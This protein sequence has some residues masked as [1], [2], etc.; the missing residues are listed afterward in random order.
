MRNVVL[1]FGW[2][3]VLLT[4]CAS[5]EPPAIDDPASAQAPPNTTS[6]GPDTQ[7]AAA[8]S[9]RVGA[10]LRAAVAFALPASAPAPQ[11][12]RTP[13]GP[14]KLLDATSSI[15]CFA[16]FYDETFTF[17]ALSTCSVTVDGVAYSC[18][19]GPDGSC[20]IALPPTDTALA[21]IG[22]GAFDPNDPALPAG[23]TCEPDFGLVYRG[24]ALQ[25][26]TYSVCNANAAQLP[27]A[28]RTSLVCQGTLTTFA[29]TAAGSLFE[30]G[31]LDPCQLR[32]NSA[33]TSC[34]VNGANSCALAMPG[35]SVVEF[36]DPANDPFGN[37]TQAAC[38]SR[39]WTYWL[40]PGGGLVET[41]FTET[42][43][44][45]ALMALAS[46]ADTSRHTTALAGS[47]PEIAWSADPSLGSCQ[48]T[49][50]DVQAGPA[51]TP[52]AFLTASG[53]TG[54]QPSDQPLAAAGDEKLV[55]LT[56]T[57]AAGAIAQKGIGILAQ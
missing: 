53:S 29:M 52:G 19:T 34:A 5:S 26:S 9:K 54:D 27:S 46:N 1:R 50:F 51:Y 47:S 15:T 45:D 49:S 20:T 36:T 40:I 32:L 17:T 28:N 35:P 13:L 57:N 39:T 37:P 41:D 4:A 25:F 8:K 10:G 22:L 38:R 55:V 33:V 7:Q 14:S 30:N 21:Q 18:A 3:L 44:D 12:P 23:S 24:G 42:C 31:V 16:N 56:C 43:D 2:A 48:I 6:N 11:A